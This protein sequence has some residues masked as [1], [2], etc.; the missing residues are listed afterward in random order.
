MVT[1]R[2]LVAGDVALNDFGKNGRHVVVNLTRNFENLELHRSIWDVNLYDFPGTA[3][4]KTPANGTTHRY[5]TC[6][7]ICF[8]LRD[9]GIRELHL[10][11]GIPQ[12]D[13][14]QDEHLAHV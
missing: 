10:I 6:F 4:E 8:L 5:S 1:L 14:G 3:S 2:N 11:C 9:Q 12:F 13:L 7:Q